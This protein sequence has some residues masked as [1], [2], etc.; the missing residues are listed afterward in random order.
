M[1]ESISKYGLTVTLDD[2]SQE[3]YEQYEPA[4]IRA[5][6]DN[7]FD[8]GKS[9]GGSVTAQAVVRGASIRAAIQ[10]GFLK[11]ITLDEV[12]KISPPAATWL[13]GK[14]AEHVKA[15]TTPPPDPN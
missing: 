2:F 15:V 1:P 6:Q 4:L 7:T 10:A 5:I 14:V 3:Q 8:F 12:K 13:A 11:G 9:G